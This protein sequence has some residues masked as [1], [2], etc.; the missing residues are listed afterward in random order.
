MNKIK[1]HFG[2]TSPFFNSLNKDVE[3]LIQRNNY[4]VKA[5]RLLWIK[6]IFYVSLHLSCYV[7]LY[8]LPHT[9]LVSFILNYVCI[10]LSGILL[11]FNVSHDACHGTFS[12]S[13]KVNYWLYHLSFNTQGT[14]AYLWKVR[15]TASHHLFP[16][17]DGCDADIDNNPMIRLSPQHPIRRHQKFQHLYALF[18]YCI[19][20]LHWFL[21][22]DLLYLTQKK[23]ANLGDK[24]YP[25][26]EWILFFVW[27]TVY[28]FLLLV[29]PVLMG[30]PFEKIIIAFFVM[31]IADSLFF[32]HSLIATHLCM[33][34][35]FPR[36]DKD[37]FLPH[38]YF[39]HQLAT[40]LD[41]SPNNLFFNWVFGGFNSHAAHHLYPKLPHTIYPYITPLIE[42]KAIEFNVQYNR[43][44]LIK[45]IKSHYKYLKI[46]GRQ[47]APH[48]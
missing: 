37:G 4:L 23:V 15:H 44:T 28:V 24:K 40:S 46:M 17:V 32:I 3:L 27:K 39:T 6:M 26:K 30:Y 43:L 42:K 20:T 35:Q 2:A 38:D 14:N 34:T 25:L 48:S 10:G 19:Y 36:P 22:K 21:F 11:A 9:S 12:K 47:T 7:I 29:L 8:A 13:K 41:F 16:N 45:A 1:F 18:I 31:H 5:R 33:E